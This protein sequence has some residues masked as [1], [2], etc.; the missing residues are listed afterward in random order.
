[1]PAWEKLEPGGDAVPT[2]A[3]GW[4]T[5]ETIER[6]GG[7]ESGDRHGHSD[8]RTHFG[9]RGGDQAMMA[10]WAYLMAA[11][12]TV[13]SLLLGLLLLNVKWPRRWKKNG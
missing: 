2:G 1:M 4:Q 13:D 8:T 5:W 11:I 10:G 7:S 6:L 3:T 12:M 9:P